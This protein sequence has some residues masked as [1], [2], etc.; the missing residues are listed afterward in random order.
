MRLT[1]IVVVIS[2]MQITPFF[3]DP[4]SPNFMRFL[5]DFSEANAWLEVPGCA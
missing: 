4:F 3:F 1:D 2:Q 5:L